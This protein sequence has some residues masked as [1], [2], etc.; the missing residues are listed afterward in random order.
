MSCAKFTPTVRRSTDRL[1]TVLVELATA[2]VSLERGGGE[3]EKRA[4]ALEKELEFERGE[5]HRLKDR[6]RRMQVRTELTFHIRCIQGDPS[7]H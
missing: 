6:L 1:Q 4:R 3:A 7:A 5:R 2:K